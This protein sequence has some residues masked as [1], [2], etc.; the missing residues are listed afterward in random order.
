MSRREENH[1]NRIKKIQNEFINLYEKK[2]LDS[3]TIKVICEKCGIEKS[4]FYTYY[5]DKYSI[6]DEIK[7]TLLENMEKIIKDLSDIDITI[8]EKGIPLIKAST[9]VEFIREHRREFKALLGPYGDPRFEIKWKA[10]I[11]KSFM[12][13]FKREKGQL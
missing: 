1:I 6:L 13:I 12:P 7:D 8:V 2:G 4:T 9:V 10:N 3:I 5:D 11:E